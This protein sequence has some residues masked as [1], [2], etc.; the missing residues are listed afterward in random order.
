MRLTTQPR[1]EQPIFSV[2]IGLMKS[3][4]A[5]WANWPRLQILMAWKTQKGADD[6]RL[7]INIYWVFCRIPN[8]ILLPKA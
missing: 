6:L 1:A 4:L 8:Q 2:D 5:A 7:F 3:N